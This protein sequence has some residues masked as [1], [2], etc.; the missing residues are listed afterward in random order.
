L[1]A[2]LHGT[3]VLSPKPVPFVL[4]YNDMRKN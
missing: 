1:G 4:F 3:A 2:S